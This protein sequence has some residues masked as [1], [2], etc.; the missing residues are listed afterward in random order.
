[1]IET[2]TPTLEEWLGGAPLIT[3]S[4]SGTVVRHACLLEKKQVETL[5]LGTVN[6][7][8]YGIQPYYSDI[9]WL[10]DNQHRVIASN[11]LYLLHEGLCNM[12]SL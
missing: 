1:M 9:A 7:P 10:L 8:M 6:T 3:I 2:N 4:A 5:V 12:G 11:A